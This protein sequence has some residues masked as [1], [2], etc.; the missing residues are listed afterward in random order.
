MGAGRS[1]LLPGGTEATIVASGRNVEEKFSAYLAAE[2]EHYLDR[3]AEYYHQEHEEAF[4]VEDISKEDFFFGFHRNYFQDKYEALAAGGGNLP[5]DLK[6]KSRKELKLPELTAEQR[7][8]FVDPGGSDEKEWNAWKSKDACE[9]LRVADS[10]RIKKEKPDLV[11][12]TRWVRTNQQERRHRRERVL[13]QVE[14]CGPSFQGQEPGLLQARCPDGIGSG[15]EY[16]AKKAIDGFAK[17][18][19]LFWL[20]VKEHLESDGWCESR[21]EPALFYLRKGKRLLGILV[22]HVDDIEL[23]SS[24]PTTCGTSSSEGEK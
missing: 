8:L 4:L 18:A 16:Q 24:P 13:G 3:R 11:I 15:R 7:K 1:R 10:R 19:R 22:T 9:I 6:K 17:A 12:P 21:L 14:A 2:S 23:W 20:A 5:E